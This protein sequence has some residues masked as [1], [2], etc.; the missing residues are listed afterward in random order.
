MSVA[1]AVVLDAGVG[2]CSGPADWGST[3]LPL[4]THQRVCM[5]QVCGAPEER[6]RSCGESTYVHMWP[7]TVQHNCF[8]VCMRKLSFVCST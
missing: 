7:Y 4:Q 2:S 1:S 5:A 3:D 8:Y 6:E